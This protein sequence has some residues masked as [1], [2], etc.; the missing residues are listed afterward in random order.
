SPWYRRASAR[1]GLQGKL[2]IC[3]MFLLLLA[4]SGSYWLFLRET[5]VSMLRTASERAA[6]LAQTMALA[7]AGPLEANDVAELTRISKELV[8]NGSVAGVAFCT[9]AGQP[10]T[11][12]CKDL[13]ISPHELGLGTQFGPQELML[14]RRLTSP[15]LG[16]VVTT[17]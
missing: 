4:L 15:V 12:A 9:P 6:A 5:Q 13:D 8:K 17:S 7:A 3:F 10:I 2:I 1:I 11:A 14:P 16:T